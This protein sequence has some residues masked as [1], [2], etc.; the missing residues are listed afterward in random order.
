MTAAWPVHPGSAMVV[1]FTEVDPEGEATSWLEA[2][3]GEREVR[4][5]CEYMGRPAESY[6][7]AVVDP[8]GVPA[9]AQLLAQQHARQLMRLRANEAWWAAGC[10]ELEVGF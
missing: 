2:A 10:P 1:E 5:L 8:R 3:V 4:E 9:A 6:L 7:E